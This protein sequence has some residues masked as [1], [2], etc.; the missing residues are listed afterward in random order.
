M[1]E[2]KEDAIEDRCRRVVVNHLDVKA[3]EVT[4]DVDF[5]DKLGADSLDFVEISMAFEEEFD[6]VIPDEALDEIK[7]FGQAVTLVTRLVEARA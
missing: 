2:A 6:V 7:T 4:A 5:V 3:E 1:S